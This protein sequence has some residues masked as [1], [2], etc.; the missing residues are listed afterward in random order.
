[1]SC[2]RH[3]AACTPELLLLL[4]LLSRGRRLSS[5]DV[6]T[7]SFPCSGA[8]PRTRRCVCTSDWV[9]FPLGTCR[10]WELIVRANTSSVFF[11]KVAWTTRPLIA[12]HRG[13]KRGMWWPKSGLC[14]AGCF[15]RFFLMVLGRNVWEFCTYFYVFLFRPTSQI[16]SVMVLKNH[17]GAQTS[18][19]HAS[20]GILLILHIKSFA[21]NSAHTFL[22]SGLS[23]N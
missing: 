7:E 15:F 17:A 4:R 21:G 1:M 9:I 19:F 10:I 11:S 14:F 2:R 22:M 16:R 3:P 20:S 8:F 6:A 13:R 5:L 12:G 23:Q 18:G